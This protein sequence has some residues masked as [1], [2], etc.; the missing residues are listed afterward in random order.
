[1][2]EESEMKAIDIVMPELYDG[3]KNATIDLW[4]FQEDET[5][6]I[7]SNDMLLRVETDNAYYDIPVPPWL[8]STYKVQEVCKQVGEQVHPGD[9]LIRVQ[10]K[11]NEM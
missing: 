7:E 6:I 2:P 8:T 11:E 4:F 10:Q 1:M 9:I 3:M 5:D